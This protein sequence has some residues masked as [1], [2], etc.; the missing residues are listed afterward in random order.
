MHARS[1]K[2]ICVRPAPCRAIATPHLINQLTPLF[3]EWPRGHW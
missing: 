2:I 1:K 3:S